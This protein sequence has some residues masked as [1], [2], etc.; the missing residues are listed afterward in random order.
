MKS[1]LQNKPLFHRVPAVSWILTQNYKTHSW[2][3]QTLEA[4]SRYPY[5]S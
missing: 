4:L 5:G 3:L 2:M 1:L